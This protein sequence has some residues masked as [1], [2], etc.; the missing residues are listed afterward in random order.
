MGDRKIASARRLAVKS[1]GEARMLS[2]IT[3]QNYRSFGN[4]QKIPLEPISILVGPNNSGKSNFLSIG[5]F[6]RKAVA[7]P[8]ILC[9]Y[10]N[11]ADDM[12]D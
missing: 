9:A 1:F 6:V 7:A 3:L 10:G 5:E 11:E 12:A 8:G 2:S 4:V